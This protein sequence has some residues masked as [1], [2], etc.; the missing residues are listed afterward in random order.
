MMTKADAQA[1][2]DAFAQSLRDRVERFLREQ[3]RTG[4]LGGV[5]FY[6]AQDRGPTALL[7]KAELEAGGWTVVIDAPNKAVTIS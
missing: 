1:L 2:I 3:A 4:T 7:V 6:T 5:F